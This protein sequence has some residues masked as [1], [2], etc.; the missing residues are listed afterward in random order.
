VLGEL[1][2]PD[3]VT[4]P[5]VEAMPRGRRV[6]LSDVGHIGGLIDAERVLSHVQ[7]FL[8]AGCARRGGQSGLTSPTTGHQT[9]LLA[10]RQK[11]PPGRAPTETRTR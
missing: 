9:P 1:Q 2:D 5:A 4:A 6:T 10:R 8:A 3:A 7:P 11:L